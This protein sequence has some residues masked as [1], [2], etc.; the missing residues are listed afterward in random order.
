MMDMGQLGQNLQLAGML[1]FC[2]CCFPGYPCG[3]PKKFNKIVKANTF[4][5]FVIKVNLLGVCR[6]N[7]GMTGT[8]LISSSRHLQ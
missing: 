3:N 4:D 5:N 6:F 2:I 8:V 7:Q 1:Q